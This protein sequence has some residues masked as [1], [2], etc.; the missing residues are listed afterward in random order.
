MTKKLLRLG[1]LLSLAGA[2]AAAPPVKEET[3][4]FGTRVSVTIPDTEA[5]LAT[6]AIE[7]VF[8]HF[9]QQ[10]ERFHVRQPGEL[11]RVNEAL[12]Q[13]EF[14]IVLSTPMEKAIRLAQD[15]SAASYELFDPGIGRLITLWGFDGEEVPSEP[16]PAR[17]AE[18]MALKPKVISLKLE[19]NR[20]VAGSSAVQLD[21]GALV[22]GMVLDESREIL[23]RHGIKNALVDIGGNIIALG[24]NGDKLW[25]VAVAPRRG[26]PPAAVINLYDGEAIA[27]AGDSERYFIAD[28]GKYYH[29]IF[30][31]RTGYSADAV[32]AATV[33]SSGRNAGAITDAASTALVIAEKALVPDILGNFQLD[34]VWRAGEEPTPAFQRRI[35]EVE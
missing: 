24:A 22:K 8:A 31:P 18:I 20:I 35:D 32:T 25:R 12:A 10:H 19:G 7:A 29:H 23:R 15:Y 27:T 34:L 30:D 3:V 11:Y 33:I 6:E 2:V 5:A 1:L 4:V 28:Q 9:Q 17:I 26:E 21:F 16:P 13:E 14:P